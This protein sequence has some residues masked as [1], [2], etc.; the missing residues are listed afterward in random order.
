MEDEFDA[1][2]EILVRTLLPAAPRDGGAV[3]VLV[4]LVAPPRPDYL[5]EAHV[6]NR[7]PLRLALVLDCSA[8]MAGQPFE[9]AIQCIHHIAAG[10][11]PSDQVALV[12]CRGEVEVPVPLQMAETGYEKIVEA[13]ADV[14]EED[15]SPLFNGWLEGAR[16]LANGESGT[17]SRI[18]VFSDGHTAD[19][20]ISAG[21]EDLCAEWLTRGV[22]TSTV[23][24]GSGGSHELMDRIARTGGGQHY[25]GYGVK[26]FCKGFDQEFALF[27]AMC[28]ESI[29]L[30]VRPSRDVLSID[31]LPPR[32]DP[33]AIR[34]HYSLTDLRFGCE[35]S[36]LFR[37]HVGPSNEESRSLFYLQVRGSCD[38][39]NCMHDIGGPGPEMENVDAETL[40]TLPRDELV[41]EKLS[42]D[43]REMNY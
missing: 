4:Q 11:E 43:F 20:D 29:S 27:N 35:S 16:Q 41:A 26:D 34:I 25:S 3:H 14:E 40:A 31:P 10:M 5:V 17:I 23:S 21:I 32:H 24:L 22:S 38:R 37:L 12:F 1:E 15:V 39:H 19:K 7:S 8:S 42:G 13:V 18:V 36:F 9:E 33:S 28:W 30:T 6:L 2:P